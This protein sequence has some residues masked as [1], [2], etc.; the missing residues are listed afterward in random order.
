MRGMEKACCVPEIGK[1][2]REKKGRD[3]QTFSFLP[4]EPREYGEEGA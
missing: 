2:E 4:A 1:R 3:L